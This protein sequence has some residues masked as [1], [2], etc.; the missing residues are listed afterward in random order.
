MD[1]ERTAVMQPKPP[2]WFMMRQGKA[3][4]AGDDL[5]RLKAP[6]LPELFIAIRKADNNLWAGLL[7]KEPGGP[8]TAS[9]DPKYDNPIDAWNAA[10]ELYRNEIVI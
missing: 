9:T 3:E 1:A 6:N 8:D 7:R 10:Y 2:F 4:P 5:L